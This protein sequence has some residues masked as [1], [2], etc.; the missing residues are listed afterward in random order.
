MQKQFEFKKG[1][2]YIDK[3]ND[4][5]A[6]LLLD[7]VAQLRKDVDYRMGTTTI[8]RDFTITIELKYKEK[9][10]HL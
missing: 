7:E 6:A 3:D 4:F 8:L 10:K 5:L 9:T 2:K 1:E